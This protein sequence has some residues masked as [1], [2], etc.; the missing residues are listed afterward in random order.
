MY[1]PFKGCLDNRISAVDGAT[2][3]KRI[4]MHICRCFLGPAILI[5]VP[6][7]EYPT[8]PYFVPESVYP[9]F[10]PPEDEVLPAKEK[11][12]HAVVSPTADSPGYVP[13]SDPE[14]D[15]EED[16]DE[17]PEEDPADYPA[18]RGDMAMIRMSYP[19]MMRMMMLILRRMRRRS[20]QLLPTLQL[21]LYQPLIMSVLLWRLKALRPTSLRHTPPYIQFNGVMLG[22]SIEMSLLHIFWS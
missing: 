6:G 20:T 2:V 13:E 18:D 8:S 17:D 14:E 7:P 3:M 10:M 22:Y 9:E 15:L 12:L 16:D 11:P 1:R 4:H 21:L 19:M 5:Y